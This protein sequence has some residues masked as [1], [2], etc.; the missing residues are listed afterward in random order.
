MNLNSWSNSWKIITIITKLI[1]TGVTLREVLSKPNKEKT[2]LLTTF[3]KLIYNF[4]SLYMSN[5]N[6]LVE[7]LSNEMRNHL[8]H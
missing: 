5:N 8:A 6:Q 1:L 7:L 2:H 3:C 4:V